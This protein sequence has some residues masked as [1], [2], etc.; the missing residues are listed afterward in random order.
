MSELTRMFKR[1]RDQAEQAIRRQGWN[2]GVVTI[3][4]DHLQQIIDCAT[5]LHDVC[6]QYDTT[7]AVP[8]EGPSQLRLDM[9]EAIRKYE[10]FN[11]GSTT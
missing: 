8:A 2:L 11:D 5:K 9:R 1:Y 4:A 10:R 6:V 7:V 3:S